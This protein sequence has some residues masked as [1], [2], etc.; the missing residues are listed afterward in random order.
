MYIYIVIFRKYSLSHKKSKEKE[1]KYFRK[2]HGTLGIKGRSPNL[3]ELEENG[4]GD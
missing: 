1:K 4:N 3:P 2:H